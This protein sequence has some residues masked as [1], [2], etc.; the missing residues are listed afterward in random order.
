MGQYF[1]CSKIMKIDERFI[2]KKYQYYNNSVSRGGKSDCGFYRLKPTRNLLPS[3]LCQED[4][5]FV[6]DTVS[7]ESQSL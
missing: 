1:T 2:N 4:V 3:N 6:T 5:T 7:L